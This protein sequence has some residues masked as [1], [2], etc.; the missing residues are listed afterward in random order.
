MSA[1]IKIRVT[2]GAMQGKEFTFAEHDTFVFGRQADCHC[3]LPD[4]RLVSRH[5]FFMEVNPPDARIRDFGSL[6]GTHVNGRKIGARAKG[7]TPE[8]GAKRAYPTAAARMWR[9]KPALAVPDPMS[10]TPAARAC[11]RIRPSL[12]ATWWVILAEQGEYDR[13]VT[14]F[15]EAISGFNALLQQPGHINILE[16]LAEAHC[17]KAEILYLTG[18]CEASLWAGSGWSRATRPAAGL[19]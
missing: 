4:D 2:G 6:N 10:A 14:T 13:A 7:E 11:S 16:K 1:K 17:G 5:H 12:S 15:D 8:T 18:N 3:C 9:R 19:P